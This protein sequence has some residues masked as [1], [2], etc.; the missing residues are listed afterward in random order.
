M[1][2]MNVKSKAQHGREGIKKLVKYIRKIGRTKETLAKEE[3][4]RY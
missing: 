1:K 3:R 4:T 2:E